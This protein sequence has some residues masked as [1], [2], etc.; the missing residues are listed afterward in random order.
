MDGGA[1][2]RRANAACDVMWKVT[3][4]TVMCTSSQFITVERHL[5]DFNIIVSIVKASFYV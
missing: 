1:D 2:W 5:V 4:L 3:W